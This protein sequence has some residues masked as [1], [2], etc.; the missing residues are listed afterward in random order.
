M[1]VKLII[2]EIR[3][4][5]LITICWFFFLVSCSQQAKEKL[6]THEK[7]S[8]IKTVGYSELTQNNLDSLQFMINWH[9]IESDILAASE[10]S[11]KETLELLENAKNG[12]LTD[13]IPSLKV[14][15]VG[16]VF[17]LSNSYLKDSIQHDVYEIFNGIDFDFLE[18][19]IDSES[20]MIV[21]I[22]LYSDGEFITDQIRNYGML[23]KKEDF[24]NSL[25][26]VP[27]INKAL[28]QEDYQTAWGYSSSIPEEFKT[29]Y[30]YRSVL[31]RLLQ[32]D[33]ELMDDYMVDLLKL[34]LDA[35]FINYIFFKQ[36]FM[37]SDYELLQ[38]SRESLKEYVGN[39][40]VVKVLSALLHEENGKLDL[41]RAEYDNII[42]VFPNHPFG[43]VNLTE[44]LLETGQ[45]KEACSVIAKSSNVLNYKKDDWVNTLG[46]YNNFVSSKMFL[47]LW[48]K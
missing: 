1:H 47:E 42:K 27:V 32:D 28:A 20:K 16:G 12:L 48:S 21:N 22:M 40:V 10:A 8:G 6:Q 37:S 7:P 15:S 13:L 25:N 9:V 4:I 35:R 44:F 26:V 39:S 45:D 30:P 34:S 14:N 29:A 3:M 41:A 11:E 43:Y 38:K 5:K 24:K 33:P 31:L 18:L 23:L 2:M 36:S 17:R 46:N 19:E